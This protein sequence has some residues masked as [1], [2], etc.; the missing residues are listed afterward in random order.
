MEKTLTVN[1]ELY[2]NEDNLEELKETAEEC[3]GDCLDRMSQFITFSKHIEII[4]CED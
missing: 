4:E 3:I 2:C 1:I